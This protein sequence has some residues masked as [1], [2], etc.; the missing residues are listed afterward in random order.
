MISWKLASL[1]YEDYGIKPDVIL[2]NDKDWIKQVLEVQ[3][4]DLL[5]KGEKTNKIGY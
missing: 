1:E 5:K 3:S 2:E 4:T